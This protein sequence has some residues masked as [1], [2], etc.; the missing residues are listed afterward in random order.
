MIRERV[1]NIGVTRPL[2]P[3]PQLQAL[4]MPPEEIGKIKEGPAMRY[5]NGQTLWDK[6]YRRTAERVKKRREKNLLQAHKAGEKVGRR[7]EGV[8][9]ESMRA[10]KAKKRKE[11]IKEKV[12]GKKLDEEDEDESETESSVEDGPTTVGTSMTWTW[13]LKGETPPPSAI[14]SRR[15]FVSD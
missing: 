6:K 7:L 3:P 4:T 2:T 5:I 11:R 8:V 12:K 14:V 9:R 15:D 10:E 1:S 13:A